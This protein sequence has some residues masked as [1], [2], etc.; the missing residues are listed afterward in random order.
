MNDHSAVLVYVPYMMASAI[1]SPVMVAGV[2]R[3]DLGL[4]I[5]FLRRIEIITGGSFVPICQEPSPG[6]DAPYLLKPM[7]SVMASNSKQN[8]QI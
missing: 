8:K 7:L 5:G 6:D 4:F 1:C 2:I 3:W